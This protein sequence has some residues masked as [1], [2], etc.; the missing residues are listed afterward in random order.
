MNPIEQSN[1]SQPLLLPR[2]EPCCP[3]IELMYQGHAI[4][5]RKPRLKSMTCA[6]LV[7]AMGG[8]EA[9]INKT[10]LERAHRHHPKLVPGFP[11]PKDL[12]RPWLEYS[13]LLQEP[14][15]KDLESK[16]KRDKI[17]SID[18]G[19]AFD[20]AVEYKEG[21]HELVSSWWDATAGRVVEARCTM[22]PTTG[23]LSPWVVRLMT[24]VAAGLSAAMVDLSDGR[25][26]LALHWCRVLAG[27]A[28]GHLS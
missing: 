15:G 27:I 18:Q 28:G 21:P 9:G 26:D 24:L 25:L 22:N 17:V 19:R 1:N 4:H 6:E 11:W 13:E 14:C 23:E 2:T 10:L 12:V 8:P 3:V 16:A 5:F 7:T 20:A